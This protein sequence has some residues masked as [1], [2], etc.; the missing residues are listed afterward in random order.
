MAVVF[1]MDYIERQSKGEQALY[2]RSSRVLRRLSLGY[3]A[4]LADIYWT[5]AAQYFGVQHH[6]GSG[7]FRLLAPLLEVTTELHPRLSPAYQFGAH[8]LAPYPP[9][10]ARLPA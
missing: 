7:D 8:F 6:N 5:R 1:G 9:N 2:L 4:L 10:A 3:T